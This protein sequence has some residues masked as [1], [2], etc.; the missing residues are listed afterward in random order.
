MR[1]FANA[2]FFNYAHPVLT[3]NGM[4]YPTPTAYTPTVSTFVDAGRDVKGVVVGQIVRYDVI[5][6]SASWSVLPADL[7]ATMLQC[8]EKAYNGKFYSQVRF[9]LPETNAYD[10]RK[11]YIADRSMQTFMIDPNTG[12]A[13]AYKDVT[14]EMVEV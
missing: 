3:V 8:W 2:V 7:A 11:M 5:A 14:F 4:V 6:I 1:S 10:T 9:L 12:K 13:L